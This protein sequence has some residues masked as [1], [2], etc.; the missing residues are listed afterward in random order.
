M[1][2]FS[3]GFSLTHML[4]L[5]R[6][7]Q[8]PHPA[9][10]KELAF[11]NLVKAGNLEALHKEEACL[12]TIDHNERGILSEDPRRNL[13][14]HMIV[15]IAMITRFCI[16]GGLEPETAYSLSDLYIHQADLTPTYDGLKTLH[17]K[18]VYDF[19]SRMHSLKKEKAYSKSI[20]LCLDYI[21]EH[22]H[23]PLTI[24]L[25]ADVVHLNKTYL[26]KRFKKELGISIAAYIQNQR[27]EAA[28]NMLLYSDY[29][30][31]DIAHFLA[32]NSHSHFISVFKKHTNMTPKTYRDKYFR[33]HWR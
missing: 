33:G 14:Y 16:E 20:I 22:L 32:F 29:T 4:F 13:L 1:T 9:Y 27:I 11:Y 8:S 26:S 5:Q 10:E 31:S 17:K 23:E 19:A 15:S 24:D 6:E 28:K 12:S 25:L 7:Y 2:D 18:M 3:S 21:Y 30:S